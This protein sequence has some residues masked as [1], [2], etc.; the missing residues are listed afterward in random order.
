MA[1]SMEYGTRE[2][3]DDLAKGYD[4]NITARNIPSGAEALKRANV[5]A[6]ERLLDVASGSGAVSIPA[7]RLGAQVLATDISPEMIERLEVRAREEGLTNLEA[8]VM[9]GQA[10]DLEDN[11]FDVTASQFGV[12][13]FPDLPRGV[14]EMVR[15]TKPG[16]RVVLAAFGSPQEVEFFGFYLGALQTIVP[17]FTPP[18]MDPPPLPFQVSDPDVLRQRLVD[19]GLRDVRIEPITATVRIQTGDELYAA[20]SNSNPIGRS[21]IAGLTD[22]QR[23]KV[24]RVLEG[25]VRERAGGDGPA[26]LTHPINVGIGTK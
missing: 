19:A 12:M 9:D 16:G 18:P 21:L 23:T 10:L 25:M 14:S 15:V 1:T 5:R 11:S 3:W 6:G 24:R 22:E 26:T 13:L 7:A 8:R 20:V 4:A 2:A 17:D